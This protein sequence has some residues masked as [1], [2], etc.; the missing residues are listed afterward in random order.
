MFEAVLPRGKTLKDIFNGLKELITDHVNVDVSTDGIKLQAMDSSHVSMVCLDMTVDCFTVFRCDQQQMTLGLNM[1]SVTQILKL[2]GNDDTVTLSCDDDPQRL[3]FKFE[4]GEDRVS[5][6]EM[7]LMEIDAEHLGIPD[8][9]FQAEITMASKEFASTKG[10]VAF[11]VTSVEGNV[12]HGNMLFKHNPYAE[13]NPVKYFAKSSP[14]NEEV[15]LGLHLDQPLVVQFNLDEK[16][17]NL[18][19]LKYFLAPKINDDD[20]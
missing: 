7:N 15:K 14:L 10:K 16:K 11:G 4:S 2:C 12:G 8:T 3:T 20:Q 18:G 5:E 17:A 13:K 1:K 6:F 19:S 9:D